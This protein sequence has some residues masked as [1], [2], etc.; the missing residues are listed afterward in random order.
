M[1]LTR[2]NCRMAWLKS[3]LAILAM[4]LAS[5]KMCAD[6]SNTDD[7]ILDLFVQKGFVT[8]QEA[9]KVKAEAEAMRTNEIQMPQLPESKWEISKGLKNV[10][11]FGDVRLRYEDRSA[12]DPSGNNI[13]LQRLRY[14]VRF[15]LRGDMFDDFYYGMRIDTSANPR[16]SWISFGSSSSGSPYQGPYGKSTA[17]INIGLAYL[18]WHPGG[19]LDITLGKMPNPLYT[20]PMV[21]DGDLNPEGAAEHI[22]YT[23]GDV[24]FFANFGQFIY[25]DLN[26]N[27]ASGGLGINVLT[28]QNTDNI[29]QLAWQAGLKYRFTTNISAKVAATIYQYTGLQ[30][31]SVNS[32]TGLSPYFGDPYVGEGA[33]LLDP[34]NAAGYAGYGTPSTLP[35]YGSLG[36]PINQVGL[37]HLLVLELPFEL[38]FKVSKLDAQI[39]GDFAYNLDGAA[40]AEEAQQAY[41]YILSQ[42]LNNTVK[43]AP[44]SAQTHD[45]KAYQIGLAIG[46]AGNLGL[47]TGSNAEKHA[48][49]LRTYWQHVEQYALDPNIIDSDIFEGR[50]NLQGIYVAFAYGITDNLIGTVRYGHANRINDKLGTGGDNQ[51]IP[52]INPINSFDLFQVDLTYKF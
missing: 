16:S 29:F 5:E 35:G 39:F 42:G 28:G 48:W 10:E 43:S 34:G 1:S 14:A 21:W 24:D 6:S 47:T 15:G 49:E 8:Q 40:R 17:G 20:T 46:S 45:V 26:P 18:G 3:V 50:E 9:D 2:I 23:V 32:G 31:S 36:Y 38:N 30:M 51:D 52:Q 33:S 25:E 27:S 41:S 44:F 22:N 4:C 7:P 11:L 19:W 37:D 13:D 12:T